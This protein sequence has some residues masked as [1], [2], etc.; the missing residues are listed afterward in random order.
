MMSSPKVWNLAAYKFQRDSTQVCRIPSMVHKMEDE[1][2][3]LVHSWVI[4]ALAAC[5]ILEAAL[6]CRGR[7]HSR[8]HR[9]PIPGMY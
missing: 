8:P 7:Q 2:R 1:G 5:D 4:V 9:L 3:R 6:V